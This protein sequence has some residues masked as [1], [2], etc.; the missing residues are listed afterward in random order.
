[1]R[2]KSS[3]CNYAWMLKNIKGEYTYIHSHK[4]IFFLL[5]EIM[6][7]SLIKIIMLTH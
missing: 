5:K 2:M 4:E 7:K 6:L 1:M 3:M